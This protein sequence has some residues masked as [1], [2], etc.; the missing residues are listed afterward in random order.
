MTIGQF[1]AQRWTAGMSARY[2]GSVYRITT[3]DFGESLVGLLGVIQNE[4]DEITMVRC[5]NVELIS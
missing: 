5:E 2:H 1:Q 3:V 4:P